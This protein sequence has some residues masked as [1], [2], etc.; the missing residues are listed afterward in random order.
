M[1]I[2]PELETVV[3]CPPR[4]GSTSL[5]KAIAARHPDSFMLYRHMEAD[6]IPQGYDRWAKVGLVRHPVERLWSLYSYCKYTIKPEDVKH[7]PEWY[8]EVRI[9]FDVT[10][11]EWVLDN[12]ATFTMGHGACNVF[13]AYQ[14]R[15]AMP[16]TMKS[17]FH[18]LR[19][20]LGTQVY[21]FEHKDFLAKRLD[22]D[23]GH[24]NG[25]HGNDIRP[26][27]I[28]EEAKAHIAKYFK[29]D[30]GQFE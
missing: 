19:P 3:V 22:I 7:V 15:H 12:R 28:T 5:K 29:W 26:S 25:S 14:V 6:A 16:E 13:A 30:L 18:T 10:F 4:T 24:L 27:D 23:L 9:P 17:Q 21:L 2:I 11:S 1:I 8:D 20:D